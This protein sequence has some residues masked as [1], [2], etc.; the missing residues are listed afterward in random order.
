MELLRVY[1]SRFNPSSSLFHFKMIYIRLKK[2]LSDKV[3]EEELSQFQVTSIIFHS[4]ARAM[5]YIQNKL[6]FSLFKIFNLSLRE[7][8]T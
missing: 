1:V 2:Q 8:K 5:I 3:N 7:D 6:K 4:N